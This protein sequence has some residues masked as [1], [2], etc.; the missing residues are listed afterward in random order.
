M[1][2]KEL[3][4]NPLYVKYKQFILPVF[5][6]LICLL[7]IVFLL[8]PQI[9]NYFAIQKT[10]SANQSRLRKLNNKI[11]SLEKID[12]ESYKGKINTALVAVPSDK[13]VPSAIGQLLFLI[14]SS[15]LKLEAM[16]I[17][18]AVVPAGSLSSYTIKIEASGDLKAV[19]DLIERV[20]GAPR[21]MNVAS[22]ELNQSPNNQL[23]AGFV[24]NLYFQQNAAASVDIDKAVSLL[25]P[26]EE[27]ILAA[28]TSYAKTVPTTTNAEIV[29]PRGKEDPFN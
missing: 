4:D 17:S 12:L 23:R 29:G 21:I 6:G 8:I 10:I 9:I 16:N 27:E 13:E 24:F 1:D 20:R 14:N 25:S 18:S 5:V 7:L 22:I 26:K 3:K 2:F 19:R 15:A 28:L 11:A